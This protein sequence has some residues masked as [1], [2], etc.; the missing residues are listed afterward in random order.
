MYHFDI[1]LFLHLWYRTLFLLLSQ[2]TD[3]DWTAQKKIEFQPASEMK[4]SRQLCALS[5]SIH[6]RIAVNNMLISICFNQFRC[7]FF[8]QTMGQ[9]PYVLHINNILENGHAFT[10]NEIDNFI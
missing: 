2:I 5:H 3:W 10:R 6:V 7:V 8:S 4:K 9:R 1:I